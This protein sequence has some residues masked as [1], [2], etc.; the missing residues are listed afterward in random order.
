[1]T[2]ASPTIV[3]GPIRARHES[4]RDKR[5]ERKR[6]ARRAI[7]GR[8]A[9]TLALV[10]EKHRVMVDVE[11]MSEFA[12]AEIDGF[13]YVVH[14]AQQDRAALDF[15]VRASGAAKAFLAVGRGTLTEWLALSEFDRGLLTSMAD[16]DQ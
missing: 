8:L 4:R 5:R 1:M 16:T 14:A 11:I 13:A 2:L 7:L 3:T 6:S 15:L 10:A 9:R 12:G